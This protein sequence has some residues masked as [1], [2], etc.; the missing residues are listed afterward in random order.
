MHVCQVK[1]NSISN[2]S[3]FLKSYLSSPFNIFTGKLVCL[4]LHF[5]SIS[6]CLFLWLL[7]L[8]IFLCFIFGLLLKVFQINFLVCFIIFLSFS[9]VSHLEC[10]AHVT[11]KLAFFLT[12]LVNFTIYF[13]SFSHLVLLKFFFCTSFQFEHIHIHI[14]VET[15]TGRKFNYPHNFWLNRDPFFI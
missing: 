13:I 6:H 14:K 4:F 2:Q 1:L 10:T 3:Q 8:G 5:F 11:F 12:F 9:H 7:A 15:L